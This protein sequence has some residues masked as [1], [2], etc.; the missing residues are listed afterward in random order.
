M[1]KLFT[2]A[3]A[4][5]T[6]FALMAQTPPTMT[7]DIQKYTKT[8][9]D[10]TA[11]ATETP[12]WKYGGTAGINMSQASFSNWN[13]G[14]DP[15]IAFDATFNYSLDYKRGNHLWTNRLE[16]AYGLNRTS[17]NG[18]R[19]TNDKIF[20]SSNYGYKVAKNLYISSMVTFNTQFDKGYDY[21]VSSTDYISRFMAPGYLSVGVGVTYTPASWVTIIASPATWRGTFVNDDKLSAAGAFGVKP[22]ERFLNEMGA[23]I[24]AEVNTPIWQKLSLYSRLDLY[25]NYLHNPQNVDVNWE[26]QLN[27]ALLDWLTANLHF[28]MIYDDDIKFGKTAASP[29]QPRLQLKEVLGI[30]FQVNF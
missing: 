9:E 17:S 7:D 10:A 28:S 20:F 11:T 4:F 22:G 3:T 5:T 13:A 26:I 29:G 12:A 27:Y 8:V 1:K 15:S 18:T 2:L 19:K 21:K 25:S 14:G 23:N 6:S 30:G 24:R 16:L